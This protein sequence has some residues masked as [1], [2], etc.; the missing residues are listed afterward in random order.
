MEVY[1]WSQR[2][3]EDGSD[4]QK[5]FIKQ[6][7]TQGTV[8]FKSGRPDMEVPVIFDVHSDMPYYLL[9]NSIMEFVDPVSEFSLLVPFKKD[10]LIMRYRR[11]YPA[12][13]AN[14][15]QTFYQVL[16]E[17]KVQL[18]KCQSKT[19]L[20]FKDADSPE[21][22]KKEPSELYFAYM[23]GKTIVQ[24]GFDA[25]KILNSMSEYEWAIKDI[26]KKEKLKVKD[27]GKLVDLF[28]MLNNQ[29]Q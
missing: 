14:T 23:P 3:D 25:A 11:F 7:W 28:V 24:V 20:L 15:E 21:E 29:L 18:L 17:G 2:P 5:K 8:K 4:I 6:E 26:L 10:S 9:G 1:S 27:E 19:I 12:I 13:Q 22:K 16:V